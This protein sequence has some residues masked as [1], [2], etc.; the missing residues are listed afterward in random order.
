[1]TAWTLAI[2]QPG[3][4]LTIARRLDL[5]AFQVFLPKIVARVCCRGRLVDRLRPAYGRYI[6]LDTKSRFHELRTAFG[7][8]DFLKSGEIVDQ[9][10][11]QLMA[12]A[13]GGILPTPDPDPRFRRGDSIIVRSLDGQRGI[14]DRMLNTDTALIFMEW[15][16]RQVPVSVIMD[17]LLAEPKS[18]PKPAKKR[19]RYRRHRKGQNANAPDLTRH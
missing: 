3:R 8:V 19:R 9:T 4:E 17:D 14:F 12:A 16:S 11:R 7:I 10:V 6:W 18:P 15:M 13:P 1:M 5:H 2:T